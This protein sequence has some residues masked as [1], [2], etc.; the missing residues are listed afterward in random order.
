MRGLNGVLS[1]LEN[2]ELVRQLEE[3]ELAYV[4]K[5][6]LTQ[7]TAYGSL[8]RKTRQEIHLHV[9]QSLEELYSHQ[10]DAYAAL[11]AQ[12]Y[13]E[14]R[15]DAKTLEYSIRAG[16]VALRLYASAEAAQHYSR[17]LEIAKHSAISPEQL[18]H[19][20]IKRGRALEMCGRFDQALQNYEDGESL[21]AQR[22]DRT[23]QLAA[24]VALATI[25]STPTPTFDAL[26]GRA[27]SNLALGLARELG[28]RPS[29]ARILWN[30]MLLSNFAG[31][32]SQAVEYG[33]QSLAIS[34]EIGLREQTAFTL[35]DLFRPYVSTGQYKRARAVAEEAREFWR[36]SGNQPMLADNLSRSAR[37]LFALGEFDRA[38]ELADEARRISQSIGNLWGQSFCR[39]FVS[40]VYIERG[41]MSKAIDGMS[42]CIRLG[43][44]S[45]FMMAQ[46]ATRADLGWLYGSLGAVDRG[47]E[48][49]QAARSRAEQKLPSFRPWAL[50][51]LARLDVLMGDLV[52]AQ[53]DLKQGYAGLAEDLAQHSF[54]ELALGDAELA[55][56][57]NEYSRVILAMDD[58]YA[59]LSQIGI[60]PFRSDAL[61]L[62]GKA[63]LER[64]DLDAAHEI[65]LQAQIQ[66][67]EIGSRRMLWQILFD[68]S[69][70]EEQRGNHNQAKNLR[71]KAREIVEF[72]ANHISDA[73]L[74]ASFLG[75][76][77]AQAVIMS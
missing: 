18:A 38:L 29:E 53:S 32:L 10:L 62:K 47:I 40:Y 2:E 68:Q 74:R 77:Q 52:Q 65:L 6:A 36:E 34:R 76:P 56:K 58:L 50:A 8:L 19:I 13:A 33:E 60:C 22:G 59:R 46:V 15:E 17:A 9:A 4:F 57:Q 27:L 5:H 44:E 49:A 51:S 21:A 73:D 54:I 37:I 63:L 7:E 26:H 48:L 61:Y 55:L 11:L 25:H 69:R 20:Y 39:M 41:E 45:G 14:A 31:Q 28:D 66:A 23:L 16:N 70:V 35:N 75:L 42:E 1:Q 3:D 12:H 72:I 71:L 67:E 64:G 24:L 43:D 30:L